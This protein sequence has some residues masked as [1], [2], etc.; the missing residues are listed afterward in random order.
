M[1]C[2]IGGSHL[3]ALAMGEISVALGAL[4]AAADHLDTTADQLS[5]ISWPAIEPAALAGSAVSAA[6]TSARPSA[7]TSDV[8][9]EIRG[10]VVAVRAA[11]TEFERAE[12][13]SADGLPLP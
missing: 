4:R 9:A 13:R 8:I 6:A 10:W 11:A 1:D 3:P 5:E 12:L 2:A 7:Q